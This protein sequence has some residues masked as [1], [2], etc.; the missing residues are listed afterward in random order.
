[1]SQPIER[2]VGHDAILARLEEHVGAAA[3]DARL[4]HAVVFS[5]PTGVGKFLAARWWAARLK[6]ESPR[7]CDGAT[8]PGCKQLAANVHPDVTIVEPEAHGKVVKVDQIRSLIPAM[9][10]RPLRKGPRIAIV[11]DAHLLSHEAQSAMLKLL[12][13]PPGYA[14]LVLVTD[15]LAKLMPTTRSR[16]QTFRF[17][18]LATEDLERVL[19]AVGRSPALAREAAI[20]AHGSVRQALA[21]TEEWLEDR[22]ELITA[23][24]DLRDGEGDI[25]ALVDD[26]VE[27]RKQNRTD[28][29]GL[30]EWQMNKI[31]TCLGYPART[32]SDTLRKLLDAAAEDDA[33]RLVGEATRMLWA[34]DALGR[35]ANAKL[36]VR[37]LLLDI[38][39]A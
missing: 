23:F 7:E 1:M 10:L 12:E 18:A 21:A 11:R 6:C 39:P 14:L 17:F 36:V 20:T 28:L 24:E 13:E 8:C 16:C 31:E 19:L 34:L 3:R 29:T 25:D 38:R 22:R 37:D 26:L 9:A 2:P 32:E 27:R 4:P 30:L 5:G 35:N 33:F 15:N